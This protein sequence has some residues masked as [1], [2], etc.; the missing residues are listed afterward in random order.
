MANTKCI[1][2]ETITN[3]RTWF[4]VTTCLY[5]NLNNRA[6]SLSTLIAVNVLI[7]SPHRIALEMYAKL[8]VIQQRFLFLLAIV[9]RQVTYM[10]CE[11]SPTKRSVHDKQRNKSFDGEWSDETLGRAMRIKMFPDSA[12]MDKITITETKEYGSKVTS[13][14]LLPSKLSEH[15]DNLTSSSRICGVTLFILTIVWNVDSFFALIFK[16]SVL[17]FSCFFTVCQS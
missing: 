15:K 4:K 9:M 17:A 6:R 14:P 1:I 7:D 2:H 12:M 3:K 11:I 16:S 10:G 5:L 8:S 13:I